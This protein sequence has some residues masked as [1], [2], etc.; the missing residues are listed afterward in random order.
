MTDL[1][2]QVAELGEYGDEPNDNGA[3]AGFAEL[4]SI[5]PATAEVDSAA[6]TL[7]ATGSGFG[8]S[9][10]VVFDGAE[11]ATTVVDDTSVTAEVDPAG[12][13]PGVVLV[14]VTGADGEKS[15]TFTPTVPLGG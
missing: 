4:T 8:D 6:L 2:R 1:N 5:S 3:P 11:L 15:F 14:S 9:S 13:S 12:T 10:V 7:T